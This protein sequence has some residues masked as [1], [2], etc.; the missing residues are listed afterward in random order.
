MGFWTKFIYA[1]IDM[2]NDQN[3]LLILRA[4]VQFGPYV[5][6]ECQSMLMRNQL[7]PSGLAWRPGM[8]NRRPIGEPFGPGPQPSQT[9]PIALPVVSH[10]V[11]DYDDESIGQVL[12]QMG[13]G[14]LM[15]IGVL[16]L[17]LGG[18][19]IFPLLLLFLPIALIGGVVDLVK[20]VI[21]LV[22]RRHR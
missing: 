7:L 1:A 3:S 10:R 22:D 20:K 21:R 19:V 5:Y 2:S 4:G 8:A 15:W 18:G 13:L 11:D 12:G 14:C 6:D 16:I 9:V 17:A